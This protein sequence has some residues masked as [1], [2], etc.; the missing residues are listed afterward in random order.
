[1]SAVK[2]SIVTGAGG[3]I[4]HHM[5]KAL[6]SRGNVVIGVDVKEPE[7][8]PSQADEFKKHDIRE[9]T[10]EWER[11]FRDADE[12]WALAADMGG[13]GFISK[14]HAL[15]MKDNVTIN[16]HTLEAARKARVKRYLFSSSAC[17]YPEHIQS[18]TEVVPLEEDMAYPADPQDGYGWEKLYTEKLCGYYH[19]EHGLDMRIVRFHNIYGPLGTWTG[20]REKAP[21]A[22]CRKDRS[23]I[24]RI[25]HGKTGCRQQ[26]YTGRSRQDNPSHRTLLILIQPSKAKLTGCL[27]TI[28]RLHP[29]CILGKL[30][31]STPF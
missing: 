14:N 27:R 9:Y 8:E 19:A 24:G 3:F 4:G 12:V 16:I 1:M 25:E 23:G 30:H 29:H 11:L 17:I 5:V 7:F 22:L 21:A 28:L 13:M 6:K 2:K 15:I 20:G 10:P 31:L 26:E 18:V